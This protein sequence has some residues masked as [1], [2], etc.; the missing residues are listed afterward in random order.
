MALRR[1]VFPVQRRRELTREEFQRYW[2]DEHAPLV[3]RH[4]RTMGIQRYVQ[5][6]TDLNA[7]TDPGRA[8]RGGAPPH[9]GVA[10]LWI[11]TELA[12]GTI[13]ERRAAAAELLADE[14]KFIDLEA[15][16]FFYGTERTIVDEL[17]WTAAEEDE[18][19]AD[20]R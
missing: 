10:E 1:L 11:D 16:P 6:H 2:R 19:R 14:R 12:E 3:R 9:D 8:A 13:E 5:V 17:G 20:A 18:A 4:A 7:E 15:S